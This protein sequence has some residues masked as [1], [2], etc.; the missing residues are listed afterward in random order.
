MHYRLEIIADRQGLDADHIAWKMFRLTP[1]GQTPL[2]TTYST[3]L[4]AM[5]SASLNQVIQGWTEEGDIV[6]FVYAMVEDEI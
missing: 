2:T 3:K 4:P 6:G 1:C 5:P